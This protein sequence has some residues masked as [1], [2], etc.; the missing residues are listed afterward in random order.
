MT[1]TNPSF[2]RKVLKDKYRFDCNC[3][4]CSLPESLSLKSDG[5]L[6]SINGLFERLMGWNTNMLSGKQVVEIV[7][8]IWEL[9]EEE[10][11]STQ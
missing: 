11:L 5:R 10:N 2:N 9:A 1:E 8:K 4:S 3:S 6:S 7:N